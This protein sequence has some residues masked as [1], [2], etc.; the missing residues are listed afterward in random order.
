MNFVMYYILGIVVVT[1]LVV[2]ENMVLSSYSEIAKTIKISTTK[3]WLIAIG[4]SLLAALVWPVFVIW[5]IACITYK[6][7]SKKEQ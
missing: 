3:F 7:Y 1:W 5:D 4:V 2:I 6:I